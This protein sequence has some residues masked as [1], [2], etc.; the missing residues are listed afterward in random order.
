VPEI[1]IDC[2]GKLKM[3][4]DCH[5]HGQIVIDI[6]FI[7]NENDSHSQMRLIM[8]LHQTIG[9]NSSVIAPDFVIRTQTNRWVI[10]Y[11][12]EIL[13]ALLLEK[14]IHAVDLQ[15]RSRSHCH[16]FIKRLL[17]LAAQDE[18]RHCCPSQIATLARELIHQQ[19]N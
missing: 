9:S 3:M 10:P 13:K 16:G 14:N 2:H 5:I 8:S 6:V 17:L 18:C 4:K 15:F 11:N 7:L 1:K 19:P 12:C